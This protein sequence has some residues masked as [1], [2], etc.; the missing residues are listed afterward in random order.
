MLVKDILAA[1]GKHILTVR[2]GMTVQNVS[3]LLAKNNYGA[4]VISRDGRKPDGIISERDIVRGIGKSGPDFLKY[5]V[6]QVSSSKVTTCEPAEDIYR[7]MQKMKKL[8]CRHMP[9]TSQGM[10]IGMI[11][12]GDILRDVMV[13]KHLA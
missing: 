9:V 2:P 10:L 8:S 4:V 7:V 11:S 1:K 12:I 3:R 6:G 13:K 5:R